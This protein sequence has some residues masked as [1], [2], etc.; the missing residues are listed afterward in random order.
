MKFLVGVLL[1]CLT[2]SCSRTEECD[3]VLEALLSAPLIE[4][5]EPTPPPSPDAG[6]IKLRIRPIGGSLG[7]V[8]KD[9][10]DEHLAAAQQSGFSPIFTN[11]DAWNNPHDLVRLR[12]NSLYF[13]DSLTHS[14]PYLTENSALLLEEIGRRFTDTLAARGGGRYR[15][16]VTSVLR[17]EAT[18]GRLRRV[19]RN[20]SANS[21]HCYGTTFDISY[22]KF[23]C[24]DSTDT[25]RTNE[26]LKNLLG[27]VLA[28][29]RSQGRCKVKHERRQGC[30]HIT[31]LPFIN[32]EEPEP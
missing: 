12:S 16:K 6:C 23:V 18:V 3:T 31:A 28:D 27:E 1:F 14:Y 26:D 25:R 2:A 8:F 11:N 30:F 22:A 17:T 5:Y 20:A 10:N 24:D 9:I 15:F 32:V 7:A 29:L 13:L 4:R 21:A 19:N